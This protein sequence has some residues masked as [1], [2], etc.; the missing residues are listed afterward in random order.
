LDL[1]IDQGFL[2]TGFLVGI[3]VETA[4]SQAEQKDE[5]KNE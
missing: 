4:T 3:A 2:V 1:E 5:P